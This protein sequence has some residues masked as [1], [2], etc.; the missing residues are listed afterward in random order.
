MSLQ[1]IKIN[2]GATR[3]I[4][5][6]VRAIFGMALFSLIANESPDPVMQQK[7]RLGSDLPKEDHHF[8]M[9]AS[10]VVF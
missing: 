10:S 9:I 2:Q 6:T 7:E 3:V 5:R 8:R 1:S 4:M